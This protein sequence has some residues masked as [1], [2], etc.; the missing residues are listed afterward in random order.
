MLDIYAR[1]K[2]G[3]GIVG[4]DN[5]WGVVCHYQVFRDKEKVLIITMID[6]HFFALMSKSRELVIFMVTDDKIHKTDHFT[7]CTCMQIY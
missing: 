2:R 6:Y 1:N 3:Q 5:R 7:P 4:V